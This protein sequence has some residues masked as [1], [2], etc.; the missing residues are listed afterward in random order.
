M[1]RRT[2]LAGTGLAAVAG[3][4]GTRRH[5]SSLATDE[6]VDT[7]IDPDAP[8]VRR[9]PEG[10]FSA[11]GPWNTDLDG[12]VIHG[13]DLVAYYESEEPVAGSDEYEYDYDG[14]TFRFATD[15]HRDAFAADPAAYTPA[16]GGYCSLGVRNGYKDG[17]HPEAFDVID[18]TLDF[19]LTPSIH[20]GWLRNYEARIESAEANWPTIKDSTESLH[21]GPGLPSGHDTTPNS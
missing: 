6:P 20:A 2:L 3:C 10:H 12:V 18:G 13:Y 16:F 19:N 8:Y 9:G 11:A 14:V 5:D 4:L 1:H 7:P 15:R 21:I 17:M